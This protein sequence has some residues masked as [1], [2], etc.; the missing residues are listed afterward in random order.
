MEGQGSWNP[1]AETSANVGLT[2]VAVFYAVFAVHATSRCGAATAV[3]AVDWGVVFYVHVNV[4][5]AV[6]FAALTAAT[7]A[8]LLRAA[9][10]S[11]IFF[12]HSRSRVNRPWRS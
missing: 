12:T 8:A 9:S 7:F 10:S 1:P 2:T 3:A 4:P 6:F 5:A 11:S